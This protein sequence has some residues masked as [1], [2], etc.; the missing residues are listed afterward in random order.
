MLFN[1]FLESGFPARENFV[2][3]DENILTGPKNEALDM[4]RCG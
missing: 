1:I 3:G 4:H 2:A